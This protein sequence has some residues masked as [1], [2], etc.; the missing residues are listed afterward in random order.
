MR[1]SREGRALP[2]RIVLAALPGMLDDIVRRIIDA[3]P[4]FEVVG[5]VADLREAERVAGSVGADLVIIGTSADDPPLAGAALAEAC[6]GIAIV[7]IDA[8][9]RGARGWLAGR[10][11][12][13]VTDPSAPELLALLRSVTRP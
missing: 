7:G 12:I 5:D 11:S 8:D 9:A 4:D 3:A 10:P 13:A 1:S 2:T 6:P